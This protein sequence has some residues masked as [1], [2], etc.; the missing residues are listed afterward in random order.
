MKTTNWPGGVNRAHSNW[1]GRTQRT[2]DWGGNWQ[3][4]SGTPPWGWPTTIAAA[5]LVVGMFVGL[6]HIGSYVGLDASH[7]AND[8]RSGK[9]AYA[10]K[11]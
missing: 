2:T 8:S 6:L 1:T 10:A 11:E 9:T 4:D 3:K 5:L 7:T